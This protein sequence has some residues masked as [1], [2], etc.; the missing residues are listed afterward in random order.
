MLTL[1]LWHAKYLLW[2]S[3]CSTY[4]RDLLC[5]QLSSLA[6]SLMYCRTSVIS[7]SNAL[8]RFSASFQ[9]SRHCLYVIVFFWEAM[10]D[11]KTKKKLIIKQITN[12]YIQSFSAYS[13]YDEWWGL[14]VYKLF[15]A[16]MQQ[17]AKPMVKWMQQMICEYQN[18]L[19]VIELKMLEAAFWYTPKYFQR[20][21]HFQLLHWRVE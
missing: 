15:K 14:T 10:E 21:L 7:S 3:C 12:D 19:I 17:C 13:A 5:L 8:W 9:A 1:R 11:E 6:L 20:Y 16:E 2:Y 18:K 4:S